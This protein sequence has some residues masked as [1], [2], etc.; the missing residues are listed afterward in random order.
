M[1]FAQSPGF[2]LEEYRLCATGRAINAP[3]VAHD[4]L[5][6]KSGRP[7]EGPKYELALRSSRSQV[8]GPSAERPEVIETALSA[9][10]Y[11]GA[12]ESAKIY[13]AAPS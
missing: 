5:S 1:W 13:E 2:V 9:I 10:N 12:L 6:R 11:C 3:S 4:M 8:K 7:K